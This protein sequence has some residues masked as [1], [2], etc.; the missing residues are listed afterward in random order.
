MPQ[1]RR[2]RLLI[3][4]VALFALA[5]GPVATFQLTLTA[6]RSPALLLADLAVGWSMIAVGL[7]V[8]DRRPGNRL[9]LLAL[10]TGFAWFA[11]DFTSATSAYLSYAATVFHGWFDPLFAI[12]ILAYPTGRLVRSVDRALAVGFLAVQGMWTV[13]Q[14]YAARPIAWWDCPT[15]LGTVDAYI[16]AAQALE[17]VGR[18]ETAGLTALSIGVVLVVANRWLRASGTARSR[19]APVVLA[20]IVLALGFT[21]GFL[22][23]TIA[24]ENARTVS[25]ELRVLVLAVL[26]TFVA[27]ALLVGILRDETAKARIADLVVRLEGL[28]TTAVLQ[29]SL[30]EALSDPSLAV[31]RWSPKEGGY[32]D[33]AGTAV[34]LP[35]PDRSTSVLS[36]ENDGQPLLNIVHDRALDD[37]PGLV[38]AAVA[39]VRL[40]IENERLQAEVM[41]QLEAVRASRARL[42][43]AEDTERRRIERDLH[44]GAQ[45]RLVSLQISLQLLRRHLGPNADPAA[46]AELEAAAEEAERA[47][48]EVRE[49]ARGVHPAVLTEAGLA[50]ALTSIAERSSVAVDLE[51]SIEGRLPAPVE[52]TAYF[53]VAEALTNAAK[54][55]RATRATVRAVVSGDR[56]RLEIADDGVGGAALDGGT[57]LRGLEDRVTALGGTFELASPDGGGTR[58]AVEL[59][60]A[61]S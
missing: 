26:R 23:Q 60:C 25:G 58:I 32:V 59:P 6:P 46:L 35:A 5:F 54:Y 11:G 17:I 48:A 21:A 55:A 33:A 40:S 7:I 38:S 53:V 42:V 45:Q 12:V 31:F 44:D 37:D 28:P 29:D 15:C 36:I 61:S 51:T 8:F 22:L 19:Q 27:V 43:E 30:R 20:G 18:I 57:G 14:A 4:I 16:A 24:P 9:G 39:A 52:A 41:T 3:A 1:V 47:V 34:A 13:A 10:A 56:L 50:A 49:L 2:R